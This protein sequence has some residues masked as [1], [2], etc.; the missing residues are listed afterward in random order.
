MAFARVC[1][2]RYATPPRALLVLALV[3][4]VVPSLALAAP[5]GT[6]RGH[7]VDD[8]L[9]S[10]VKIVAEGSLGSGDLR[11]DEALVL[12]GFVRCGSKGRCPFRRRGPV[13]LTF[14]RD[15]AGHIELQGDSVHPRGIACFFEGSADEAVATVTGRFY[16]ET[17]E[18]ERTAAGT[19][20]LR[21]VRP[22][23]LPVRF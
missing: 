12:R 8:R 14:E 3:A 16:C 9:G 2:G 5:R 19:F 20:V 7:L 23:R 22:R 18:E 6:F 17:F 11:P 4:A 1:G 15:L 21:R 10:P 13:E